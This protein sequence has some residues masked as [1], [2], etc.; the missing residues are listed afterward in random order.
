MLAGID[1]LTRDNPVPEDLAIVVDVVEEVVQRGD[2]LGQTT[3]DNRPLGGSDD[4]G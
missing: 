3:L 1:Q 4:S 2:A